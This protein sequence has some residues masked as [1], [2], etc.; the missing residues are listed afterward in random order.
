M[1][2]FPNAPLDPPTEYREAL[3]AI[4]QRYT[5]LEYQLGVL[6]RLAAKYTKPEQTKKLLSM[7]AE[8]LHNTVAIACRMVADRVIAN[9]LEALLREVIGSEKS[10]D[11]YV[12]SIYGWWDDDVSKTPMRFRLQNH[13]QSQV[14]W[15]AHP[16]SPAEL[17]RFADRIQ[18]LIDRAQAL[19]RR[20]K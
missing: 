12:H 15:D 6:V 8:R 5:R 20:M 14:D 4:V 2:R 13:K 1:A 16:V 10:R 19:T 11:D 9:D 7:R 3:G 17:S 18:G